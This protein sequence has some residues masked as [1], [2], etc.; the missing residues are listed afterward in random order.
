MTGRQGITVVEG[1]VVETRPNAMF[2]VEL[3]NGNR[4]LA[5]VASEIRVTLG[6]I[7]PGDCV[8]LELSPYDLSRGRITHRCK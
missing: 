6:R 3:E 2:A 5:H 7:I 1:R 8:K 4:V